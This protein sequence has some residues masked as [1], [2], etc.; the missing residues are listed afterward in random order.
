MNAIAVQ[1]NELQ[2]FIGVMP[3][4]DVLFKEADTQTKQMLLSTLVDKIIVADEEITIKFKIQL[5]KYMDK[6]LRESIGSG[7]TPYR[8][9][10]V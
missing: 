4:W 8:P 5:E 2:A 9:C 7:T 1:N 10:S 6:G 3:K